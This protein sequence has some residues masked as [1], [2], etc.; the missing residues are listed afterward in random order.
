MNRHYTLL[1]EGK[2]AEVSIFSA[3]SLIRAKLAR[4]QRAEDGQRSRLVFADDVDKKSAQRIFAQAERGETLEFR[5][6]NEARESS[7]AGRCDPDLIFAGK[8]KTTRREMLYSV[9]WDAAHRMVDYRRDSI[10]RMA[11]RS[12]NSVIRHCAWDGP[13]P[14]R[15]LADKDLSKA[16]VMQGAV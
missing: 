12:G 3:R 16:S 14:L 9:D 13:P 6:S 10:T 5:V 7:K 2:A 8:R 11:V 1:H 15:Y 4:L